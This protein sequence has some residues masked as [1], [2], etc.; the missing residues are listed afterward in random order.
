MICVISPAKTLDF[1]SAAPIKTRSDFRFA[2]QAQR[3]IEQLKPMSVGD[4][5]SMMKLSTS[6]AELNVERFRQWQP[7]MYDRN[8]KQALFAFK[9]D[10]YTGLNA[11][12]LTARQITMA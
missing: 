6:L 9:G 7:I 12:S 11:D 8:R 4:I 3:L 10:V 5:Q 1:E 2:D